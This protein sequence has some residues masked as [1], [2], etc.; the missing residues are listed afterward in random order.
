[1][2]VGDEQVHIGTDQPQEVVAVALDA[3]GVGEG[4]RHPTARALRG[5][6]G[7]LEGGDAVRPVE[8][9]ALEEDPLGRGHLGLVDVGGS[10][11]FRDAKI[12]R[13]RPLAVRGD[14]HHAAPGLK[15]GPGR[16]SGVS[17]AAP[18]ARRSWAKMR[19]SWSSFTLPT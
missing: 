15:A 5:P 7:L 12:G 2:L 4:D 10:E 8:A 14:E 17:K 19:P 11:E 6:H 3:E 9:V 18:C 1:M 16:A 13:H